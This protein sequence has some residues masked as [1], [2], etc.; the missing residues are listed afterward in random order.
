MGIS[1]EL[2]G[3]SKNS[4]FHVRVRRPRTDGCMDAGGRAM[5]DAIAE[6]RSVYGNHENSS[7]QLSRVKN[8][9]LELLLSEV[10]THCEPGWF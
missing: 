9:F 5:Q 4:D 7:A 3:I 6:N 2:K 8:T 1:G 10:Y